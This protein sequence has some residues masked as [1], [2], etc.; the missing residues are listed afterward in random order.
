MMVLAWLWFG[1]VI[2]LAI[3]IGWGWIYLAVDILVAGRD[4]DASEYKTL[5]GLT[6]VWLVIGIAGAALGLEPPID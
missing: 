1:V 2:L 3:P 4:P 6:L 5:F